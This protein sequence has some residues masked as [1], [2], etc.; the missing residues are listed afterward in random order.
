MIEAALL[1]GLYVKVICVENQPSRKQFGCLTV[2][3]QTEGHIISDTYSNS[4]DDSQMANCC[5][6]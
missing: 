1:L 4:C 5:L 2:I 6:N 3:K